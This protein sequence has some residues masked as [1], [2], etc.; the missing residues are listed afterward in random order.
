MRAMLIF[1]GLAACSLAARV[2]GEEDYHIG[3]ARGPYFVCDDRVVEVVAEDL[4]DRILDRLAQIVVER[5]RR[6]VEYASKIV[7][8]RLQR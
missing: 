8:A 7:G 1:W 6:P 2:Y 3:A 4:V 5:L